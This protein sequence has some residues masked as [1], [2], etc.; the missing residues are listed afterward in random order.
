LYPD[1]LVQVFNRYGENVYQT[2]DYTSRP[3]DGKYKGTDQPNGVF[4]YLIQ[5]NDAEKRIL[6]GYVTIIR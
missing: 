6:K 3:W 5:L 1:A 4:V 2:K